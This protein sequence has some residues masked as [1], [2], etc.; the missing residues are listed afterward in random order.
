M[1]FLILF[2]IVIILISFIS[3]R[4]ELSIENINIKGNIVTL[5]EDILNIVNQNIEGNYFWLFSKSNF[6]IFPRFKI[7][8]DILDT[9]LRIDDLDISFENP[10]TININITE[11][12]PFALYCKNL[13]VQLLSNEEIEDGLTDTATTTSKNLVVGLLS[14]EKDEC[15][16][17][18]KNA[19]IY[20]KSPDF[21][22]DIYFKYMGDTNNIASSTESYILG[23]TYLS[24]AREDQF[25]KVNLFIIY[26][27]NININVYRL[28]VKENGD[29]ELYFDDD[30]KL[31]FDENQDFNVIFENLQAVLVDIEDLREEQFEYIDLRFDNK[32]LYKFK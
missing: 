7:K 18:D 23:K 28:L 16:F 29:Y 21:S 3:K 20:E 31:I 22:D 30:S 32:I 8:K 19:Y 6:L 13:V 17:M 4:E 15:Y 12:K 24:Q 2:L 25:D 26:L 5:N 9:I 14:K 27:K 10:Q 1:L 11:R